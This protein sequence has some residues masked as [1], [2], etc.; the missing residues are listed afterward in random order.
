M[1]RFALIFFWLICVCVSAGAKDNF[2]ISLRAG[3]GDHN[4]TAGGVFGYHINDYVAFNGGV[5]YQRV[6]TQGPEGETEDFIWKVENHKNNILMPISVKGSLP[7][8]DL[9]KKCSLAFFLEPGVI[10]HLFSADRFNVDYEGYRGRYY[11]KWS[12]YYTKNYEWIYLFW[13]GQAGVEY[14]NDDVS[15]SAGYEINNQDYLK[16]RRETRLH[17]VK[18]DDQITRPRKFYHNAF[19]KLTVFF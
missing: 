10:L 1:K 13:S 5:L 17:G 8:A 3:A 14:R 12:D 18:F 16:K 19:V 2:S 6:Y 15:I 9:G 4:W 7:F 11:E